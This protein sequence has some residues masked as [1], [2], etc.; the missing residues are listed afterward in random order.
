MW[1]ADVEGSISQTEEDPG[2][3]L[4]ACFIYEWRES[5]YGH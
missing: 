2:H 1:T 3:F 5:K 4:F